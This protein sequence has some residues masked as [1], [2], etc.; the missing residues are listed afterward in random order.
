MGC[1]ISRS[2]GKVNPPI[3]TK[4]NE[5][6]KQLDALTREEKITL[7]INAIEK[8]KYVMYVVNQLKNLA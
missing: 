5:I 1:G 2:N 8:E 7:L 3:K 4:R 6:K